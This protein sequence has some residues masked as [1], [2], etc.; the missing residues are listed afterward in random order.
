M[1]AFTSSGIAFI[2]FS[3][4]IADLSFPLKSLAFTHSE[5]VRELVNEGWTALESDFVC[6]CNIRNFR[7]FG[8]DAELTARYCNEK[9]RA[10]I[11]PRMQPSRGGGG[12]VDLCSGTNAALI[13]ASGLDWCTPTIR[14][15]PVYR[16][17]WQF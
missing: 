11:A 15:E 16:P 4:G 7:R 1:K 6:E 3:A 8:N 5:C 14:V 10:E 2:L 17:E 12:N 13:R 9:Y